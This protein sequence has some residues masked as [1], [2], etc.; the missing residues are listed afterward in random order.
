M[1]ANK[2][3]DNAAA[4]LPAMHMRVMQPGCV[5]IGRKKCCRLQ[6]DHAAQFIR[7]FGGQIKHNAPANRTAHYHGPIEPKCLRHRHDHTGIA[8]G[9]ELIGL[10]LPTLGRAGFA[11]PGHIE[12]HAAKA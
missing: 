4:N 6:P 7:V 10:T 12:G 1:W 5:V 9:G 2:A 3:G 11:M 8:R